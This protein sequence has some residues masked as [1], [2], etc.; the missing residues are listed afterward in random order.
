MNALSA[1]AAFYRE[2]GLFMH[3]VLAIGLIVGAIVVERVLVIG[4]AMRI[5]A[6]AFVDEIVN[7]ARRG[8]WN[9]ARRSAMQ[10][11]VP[12][13]RV[14][15]AMLESGATDEESLQRAADDATTLQ[16]PELTKR[17]SY[18]GMLANSATLIGLLGTITGLITAISGVGI[19][20]AATR[21][22]RLSAG[23]SEALHA[24][25]FGLTVA[26]PTLLVQGWLISR[27]EEL[28]DQIDQLAIRLGK[29]M[30]SP[31]QSA[32]AP[33]VRPVRA[34]LSATPVRQAAG[35]TGTH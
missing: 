20:D 11:G 13:A 2:G 23:I 16:M 31:A 7:H 15:Q 30:S 17:L 24:T 19:A 6:R 18:L 27:V 34:P 35:E 29:V 25:A 33:V 10:S 26:I 32:A 3:V 12:L 9:G 1:V 14:A 22:A 28:G 8:D 4:K 5:D 21:S